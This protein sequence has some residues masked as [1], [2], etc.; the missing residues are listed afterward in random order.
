MAHVQRLSRR[1]SEVFEFI[2]RHIAKTAEPPTF[3]EIA[4]AHK[5]SIPAVQ[6]H[7]ECLQ[8]K[9][10]LLPGS[11]VPC[12]YGESVKIVAQRYLDKFR[13]ENEQ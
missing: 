4:L 5:I 10:R 8:R 3:R 2:L 11:R 7:I 12:G 13:T 1:Q 9:E 6:R